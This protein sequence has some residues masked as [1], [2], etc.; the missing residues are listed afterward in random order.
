[1]NCS[2]YQNEQKLIDYEI[3]YKTFE[4]M[5]KDSNEDNPECFMIEVGAF[6]DEMEL[7]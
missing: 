2:K 4:F 5:N 7:N 1:M 6:D 3:L